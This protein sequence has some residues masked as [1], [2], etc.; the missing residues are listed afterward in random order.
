[1]SWRVTPS[2]RGTRRRGWAWDVVLEPGAA[3][4]QSAA[5]SEP[6]PCLWAHR[7]AG[8]AASSHRRPPA[9]RALVR[10]TEAAAWPGDSTPGRG[11]LGPAFSSQN[12]PHPLKNVK[13]APSALV[14][15]CTFPSTPAPK[16]DL[17]EARRGTAPGDR[18][19]Q[20][21]GRQPLLLAFLFN[22]PPISGGI[23]GIKAASKWGECAKWL[24]SEPN[25]MLRAGEMRCTFKS[26]PS[27]ACGHRHVPAYLAQGLIN[28]GFNA[29][30]QEHYC[31]WY[32][33]SVI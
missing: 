6:P 8:P 19:Q 28:W 25:G 4:L 22:S 16:R 17:L 15:R 31:I 18:A 33:T 24:L 26:H 29:L 2:Q 1:M 27:T 14:S 7:A 13:T 10:P 9:P 32:S 11:G 5:R 23:R 30:L 21:P 3:A 20:K 12:C